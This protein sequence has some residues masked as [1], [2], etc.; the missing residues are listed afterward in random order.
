M[1]K[2]FLIVGMGDGIGLA[3]SRRFAKEGFAIAM[4]ARSEAKLQ[5]F[6][7]TLKAEGYSAHSFVADAG[8]EFSLKAAI[9]AIQTQLGNPEVLIYNVAVPNM[10]NVLDETVERLMSDFNAN[11][12]GALVATQAVLPAMKAQGTGTILFTGGGF[13]MY[14]SPDFAS[15]SIGKAGIRSL[16]KMLA[17]ALKPGGVRVGTITVCGIVNPDDPKYNPES[18]AENYWAFHVKTESDSEIIY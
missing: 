7:D 1:P 6:K 11:V 9:A 18:I 13:S 17:E 14:P 12:T 10:N 8:D 4:I 15:L 2:L 5:G 16:A 3:V